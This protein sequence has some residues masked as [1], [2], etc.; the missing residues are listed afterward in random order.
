MRLCED[1]IGWKVNGKQ[2]HQEL[3]WSRWEKNVV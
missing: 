1:E 3:I 2:D